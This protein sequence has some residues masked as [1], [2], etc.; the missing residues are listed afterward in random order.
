MLTVSSSSSSPTALSVIT[1]GSLSWWLFSPAPCDDRAAFSTTSLSTLLPPRFDL[2]VANLRAAMD[3]VKAI[4]G[5]E[6]VSVDKENLI[7]HSGSDFQSHPFSR[8]TAKTSS[9]IAYPSSTEEVSQ[10]AKVCHW[11]RIPITP[12]SGGTS[13][14][15]ATTPVPGSICIDFTRMAR[16]EINVDDMDCVVQPGVGWEDLNE[17][18]E[19]INLSSLQT[20]APVP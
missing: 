10:I 1:S 20:Q 19:P 5:D 16:V 11:R 17:Q 12:Y 4:I 18:L 2:S 6:H 3:E 9:F 13:I 15:D 8:A 14:E 7:T